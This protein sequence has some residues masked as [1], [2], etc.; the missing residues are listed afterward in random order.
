MNRSEFCNLRNKLERAI[1]NKA[2]ACQHYD[3]V[4]REFMEEARKHYPI[5]SLNPPSK[6]KGE[7]DL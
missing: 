2:F 3:E 4:M 5:E 1:V 6:E 7:Y